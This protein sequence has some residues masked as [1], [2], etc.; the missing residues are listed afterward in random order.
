MGQKR[1]LQEMDT[2][3]L[4]KTI[5]FQ[6]VRQRTHHQQ[7]KYEFGRP[8]T[9]LLASVELYLQMALELV[10][11]DTILIFCLMSART[12]KMSLIFGPKLKTSQ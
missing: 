4:K 1:L 9:L 10:N 2:L 8:L 11:K 5:H 6:C 7:R 12:K 3:E